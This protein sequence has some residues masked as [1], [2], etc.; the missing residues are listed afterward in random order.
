MEDAYVEALRGAGWEERGIYE[1]TALISL[2]SHKRS[3]GS[4]FGS[5]HGR[6]PGRK[7]LRIDFWQ[8]SDQR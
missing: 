1:A 5:A 4:C 2:F 6:D 7:R 3:D 8:V